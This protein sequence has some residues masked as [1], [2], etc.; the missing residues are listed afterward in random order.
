MKKVGY[1][2]VALDG[3]REHVRTKE[4][5]LG[6]FIADGMLAKAKEKAGARIAITNGGGIRAGI[7]KGDITLGEVLNV[8]P[9]GNTLYVADLTGKQIKEALEQ[10]LSNV[11]NGGG[12]FPQVAGIE[13]TFTLNN[14]PGHRVLDVKIES[15]NGDKVAINTD[16]TYRVATNNFVGAGGDGYSVF[17]EASHGEDLGYVDYEIFTEQLKKLGNKVSP[18]VEG[19]IKEVFLPT[20]QKDG[21]WTLDEDKFEIYAKNANTPLVY[22]GTHEGSQEKPINLKVK[23]D[24]IKLLK[25]RE[26]DPSL[27]VFNYWYSMKMPM[28]NLKTADT[29]IGI[30][31]T[32]ELNVSL[33]DVYDFTVKQKGKEIKSFKEPVQ[34]SLRMFDIEEAHNPAIY[35]VDRKK[36]AF[37]K[38]DH[39]SV[40]DDMVTGYTNHFS[41][42]TILNSGSNNKPPVFPSDQPTGGDDGSHGGSSDKPGGKQP[43]DG[44]GGND[45]PPGTQPTNGSGGSG[46]D[47]PAGGLLPDTQPHPCTRSYW[48]DF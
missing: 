1:T 24:Q 3:Q 25:E 31:S 9:F 33:A 20:K 22:Y 6:N 18:K 39:G 15:P 8:M 43:T 21:A 44:N 40:D 42:Y 5:N 14:E 32:G 29:A 23:K 45:T 47:G 30:K 41:E 19:R 10:G 13:Y 36:R 38:T 7:N 11:E 37:T 2:D 16:D 4:T 17:T 28:A 34:L 27:T 35:H 26:S 48:P 12:A 46:T